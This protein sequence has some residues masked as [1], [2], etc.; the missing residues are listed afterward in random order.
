[1]CS[2]PFTR[3]RDR[4]IIRRHHAARASVSTVPVDYLC[5]FTTKQKISFFLTFLILFYSEMQREHCGF[6][7]IIEAV[8]AECAAD[9]SLLLLSGS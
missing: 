9:L 1:M 3:A 8:R 5:I 6:N 4:Q 7:C 2:I